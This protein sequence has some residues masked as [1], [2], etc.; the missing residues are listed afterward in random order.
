MKPTSYKPEP[1][2]SLDFRYVFL[3]KCVLV[4]STSAE[5]GKK[6]FCEQLAPEGPQSYLL[7]VEIMKP[8][9]CSSAFMGNQKRMR[10][11]TKALM[12]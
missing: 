1:E 4:I 3:L 11:W 7:T 2:L 6:I 12:Q 9:P 5:L 10:E 8:L